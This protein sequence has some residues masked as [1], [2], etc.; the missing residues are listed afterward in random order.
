MLQYNVIIIKIMKAFS[1]IDG[2]DDGGVNR[3]GG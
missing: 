2:V 1:D 3:E